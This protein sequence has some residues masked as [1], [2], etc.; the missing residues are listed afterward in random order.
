MKNTENIDELITKMLNKEEAEFYHKLDEQGLPEMITNLY[1][2]KL[3]WLTIM[4]SIVM[5]LFFVLAVYSSIKLFGADSTSKMILWG[6]ISFFS[7]MVVGFLKLINLLQMYSNKI[8]RE[9]K[10]L[11]F[12]ISI[13]SQKF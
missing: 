9:M 10:R 6:F 2:G 1:N 12:Q 13:L 4:I 7:L 3:K 11:E 5:L 8:S